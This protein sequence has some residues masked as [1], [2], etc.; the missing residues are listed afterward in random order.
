MHGYAD[1]SPRRA[2]RGGRAR[3]ITH[4]SGWMSARSYARSRVPS[5]GPAEGRS[6]E[7]FRVA[8]VHSDYGHRDYGQRELQG[9]GIK[10]KKSRRYG[11]RLTRTIRRAVLCAAGGPARS[12]IRAD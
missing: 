1:D 10:A 7:S 6:G 12:R 4:T 8:A 5:A 2:V 9:M 11:A 3:E